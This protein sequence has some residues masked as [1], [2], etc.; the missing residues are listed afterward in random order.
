MLRFVLLAI[1]FNSVNWC[2]ASHDT[3]V[4]VMT[5][6]MTPAQSSVDIIIYNYIYI[7]NNSN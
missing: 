4:L 1:V 2:M 5:G 3:V 7:V 6:T